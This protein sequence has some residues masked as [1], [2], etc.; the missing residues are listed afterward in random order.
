MEHDSMHSLPSFVILDPSSETI[1]WSNV[2]AQERRG[3]LV[4]VCQCVRDM[5]GEEG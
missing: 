2:L 1:E 5:W 4:G 3:E